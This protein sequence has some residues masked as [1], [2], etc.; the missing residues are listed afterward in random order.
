MIYPGDA[1]HDGVVNGLDLTIVTGNWTFTSAG[2][3]GQGMAVPEPS[4]IALA[5]VG[6]AFLLR[7]ISRRQAHR[8][9]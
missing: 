9:V 7:I 5:L 4:S 2:S 8:A 1:N 6:A 3:N